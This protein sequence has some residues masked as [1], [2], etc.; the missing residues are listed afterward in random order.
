MSKFQEQGIDCLV[1]GGDTERSRALTV[2]ED[3]QNHIDIKNK[4]AL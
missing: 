1:E 4:K 2:I 3:Y